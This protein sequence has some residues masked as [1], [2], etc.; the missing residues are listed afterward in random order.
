[1]AFTLI[2][3]ATLIDGTGQAPVPDAALIIEDNLIR[4]VGP[5]STI[6]LP[7]A[8]IV[9][10]D[11]Q[12]G[13][14]LPG[15]FDTHVH[16]LFEGFNMVRDMQAPFSLRFYKSIDYMRRTLEAGVTSVRD[17]GGAD[18]GVKQS[19]EDGDVLGPRMQISV[20][21]LTITG[22]HGDG[23]MLSGNEWELFPAYPGFPHGRVDGAEHV[24]QKVRQ[25]LRAGAEVVKV[26]A[27]GGVLSPTDH[28][29]FIQFSPQ[30]LRVI[31][32]EAAFRRGVKVMAHA[33]GAEGIKNAVRAGIHSIEH[34]VYLDDEAIDLML[35]HGTYL[36]PT[37]L[38]PLGVLE[39]GESGGMPD[40]GLRKARE[41]VEIHS[42]SISKA[43]QAGVKIAM[44][45]DSAVTPHGQ[46]LRELGLMV[47]IGMSPME[48]IVASTSIAAACL[49]WDDRLGTL[50]SGK[51]ADLILVKDD[52]LKNIRS[53]ENVDNISLVM[54]DGKIVKNI[55]Q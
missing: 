35:E 26:C 36:V 31:V 10:I 55:L 33:Q 34:G 42:Q 46:N 29:E 5:A 53:L 6:K 7:A 32:E 38:A 14:I 18:A 2:R 45:T 27:T 40:Y 30:E 16:L 19:V 37:L 22:G 17:A 9:E 3:N 28:P 41:V 11:A 8:E 13:F 51:L 12:G 39:V 25:V 24:R 1:M 43:H 50:E 54:K 44:G 4:S 48:A 15:F 23:W 52:P 47:S 21:V 20:S 49:G